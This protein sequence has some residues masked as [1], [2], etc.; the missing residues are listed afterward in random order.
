LCHRHNPYGGLDTI[1]GSYIGLI[2]NLE[3]KMVGFIPKNEINPITIYDFNLNLGD[4]IDGAID[5]FIINK[6]DSIEIC[7]EYHKRYV[8]DT[9]CIVPPQET[10]I[11]GVGF[12]NGLLGCFN[13]FNQGGES[14]IRLECYSEF[15][16]EECISCNYILKVSS[17]ELSFQVFPNP[18]NDKLIIQSSKP[19]YKV[20]V[21]DIL[22]NILFT[23]IYTGDYNDELEFTHLMP[24]IYLF[25]V[26]FN[27]HSVYSIKILKN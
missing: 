27:D 3:D 9:C 1:I 2:G 10:L 20:Q 15:G 7:G 5:K 26:Q 16:N 13:I 25:K 23:K 18:I 8:Q 19:I 4:T 22:G 12:S 17:P 6:I 14:T 11:E 21:Y 24:N